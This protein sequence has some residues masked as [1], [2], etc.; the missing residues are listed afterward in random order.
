MR[1][2]PILLFACAVALWAQ[3]PLGTV[4]GL[5]SDPSGAAVPG[6]SVTLS[7]EATG[8]KRTTSSNASGAYSFPDLPP[9]TYRLTADAK[10][11][12]SIET[13][14]FPLDA[15]RTIRQDL[16]FELA[17]TSSE[18]IVT[19]A[20]PSA[21]ETETPSVTSS[22]SG[23]EIIELPTNLRSVAKNSGDSGLISSMMPLTIPGVVQVGNG[24]KWLTPGSGA[25]SMKVKVD[26]IET[27]FANFGSPDNVSQPSVEAIQEF[28]ANIL[29]TRAEFGGMGTIT[30]VTRSGNNRF[31]GNVFWYVRNSALDARNAYTIAKPYQNLHTYGGTI[32]GPIQKDKTFFFGDFDGLR[33]T[34]AYGFAPNVPTLAMRGGDF[35]GF[36]A[37]RNPFTNVAFPA[38]IIPTSLL[39]SQALSAQKL[40]YPLPNFGAPNL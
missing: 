17:T 12:R 9:A 31:H 32:G 14:P 35:T 39:S 13:R 28:A 15:Y 7:N 20:S 37:I 26:G 8:V 11:F 2:A 27:T 30:S 19:D 40:L 38:N 5:A 18:V 3:T 34:A 36:P 21:I 23:R 1:L 4:T 24:A 10:G 33:G 25:A 22:L 6:A 16:R 29:T